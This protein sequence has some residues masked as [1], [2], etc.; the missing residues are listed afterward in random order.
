V[1]CVL[2]ESEQSSISNC[3][4]SGNITVSN[5]NATIAEDSHKYHTINI[6]GVVGTSYGDIKNCVNEANITVNQVAKSDNTVVVHPTIGGVVGYS[7]G[8]CVTNC[9]NGNEAKTTG[10]IKYLDNQAAQLYT[11]HVAGV[12]GMGTNT[13]HSAFSG[14]TNYGAIEFNANAAGSGAL[15]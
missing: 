5:P 14:N 10:A 11:P 6:A 9:V 8:G 15:D 13:N 12:A 1:A 3:K 7:I 4:V 2:A